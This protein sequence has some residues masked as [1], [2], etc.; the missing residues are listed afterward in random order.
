MNIYNENIWEKRKEFVEKTSHEH[1]ENKK[2]EFEFYLTFVSSTVLAYFILAITGVILAI[3]NPD[4]KLDSSI[5]YVLSPILGWFIN[6]HFFHKLKKTDVDKWAE[7]KFP[8]INDASLVEKLDKK[9]YY[10]FY[11]ATPVICF[12]NS[13]LKPY[14]YVPPLLNASSSE[15]NNY[16]WATDI[17]ISMASNVKYHNYYIRV[18]NYVEAEALGF[19]KAPEAIIPHDFYRGE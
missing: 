19:L 17:V 7:S 9:L 14:Y 15:I 18:S 5:F 10:K 12:I 6:N 11:P 8:L 4:L 3:N 13:H 2:K 1:Q 16:K